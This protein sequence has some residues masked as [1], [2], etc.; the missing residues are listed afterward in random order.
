MDNIQFSPAYRGSQVASIAV[1]AGIPLPPA[2]VQQAY[3]STLVK[4][5]ATNNGD[6]AYV[7][8]TVVYSSFIDEAVQPTSSAI[9]YDIRK[10]GVTNNEVQNICYKQPGGSFYVCSWLFRM[11]YFAA[12]TISNRLTRVF[13]TTPLPGL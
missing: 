5:L 9:L 6:S 8:S 2:L 10:I 11:R 7:P 1:D 3:E 12:L 4:V 13:C